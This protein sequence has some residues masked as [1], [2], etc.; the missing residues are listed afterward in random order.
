MR[1]N[2]LDTE[3]ALPD[4]AA[5]MPGAPDG[6]VLPKVYSATD[7][8]TLGHYLCAL[9]AREGLAPGS[10][11]VHCVATET[12]ASLLTFAQCRMLVTGDS[13]G[14]SPKRMRKKVRAWFWLL[15]NAMS[16]PSRTR[17]T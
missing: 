17:C 10:T 15:E 12:A 6:I 13:S 16:R 11:K 5:V 14:C 9:E 8:N 1:I 3:L 2:P 4:L 7:V